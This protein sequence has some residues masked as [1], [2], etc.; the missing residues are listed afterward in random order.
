MAVQNDTQRTLGRLLQFM[1]TSGEWQT[2]V[3][4]K[5]DD[6]TEQLGTRHDCYQ[7]ERIESLEQEMGAW[8]GRIKWGGIILAALGTVVAAMIKVFAK[9]D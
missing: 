5:L 8:R 1:E 7:G 3:D 2:R 6:I 4:E 9:G